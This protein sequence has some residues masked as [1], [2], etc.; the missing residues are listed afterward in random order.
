QLHPTIAAVFF[1]IVHIGMEVTGLGKVYA[2]QIQLQYLFSP[3]EYPGFLNI[4]GIETAFHEIMDCD[5]LPKAGSRDFQGV[6]SP[7]PVNPACLDQGVGPAGLII[8]GGSQVIEI[9]TKGNRRLTI[10]YGKP[11]MK[12]I[13]RE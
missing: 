12:W 3:R 7:G 9:K 11:E 4:Q 5:A 1:H 10:L 8:E 2:V 6:A 13:Q